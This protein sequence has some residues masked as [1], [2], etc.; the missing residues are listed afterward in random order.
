MNIYCGNNI[1]DNNI[2]NGNA[3]VGTRYKCLKKGIGTGLNMPY[4]SKYAGEY[5]P[6]DNTKMYCGDKN[7]LPSD[8]DVFGNLPQCLQKGVAI[9]KRKR[10][11][12]GEPFLYNVLQNKKYT[13]Y[14]RFAF[15]LFL[16]LIIF[17][18]L[19]YTKPSFILKSKDTNLNTYEKI[20][21]FQKFLIFYFSIIIP[22]CIIIFII[23][24]NI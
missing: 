11:L 10:A 21:D 13:Y 14:Y 16:C 5:E 24:I 23:D 2:V 15:S 8:Y 9:G 1:L 7:S 6:I 17:L 12:K 18:F 3:V 4:D 19:Y 20:I 22:L